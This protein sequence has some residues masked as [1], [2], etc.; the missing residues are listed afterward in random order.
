MTTLTVIAAAIG[1]IVLG[2]LGLLAIVTLVSV[3]HEFIRARW[4]AYDLW[5]YDDTRRWNRKRRNG[6]A[7]P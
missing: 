4:R 3:V 5:F 6:K 2:L 1:F 7:L